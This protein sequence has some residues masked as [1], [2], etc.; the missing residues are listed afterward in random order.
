MTQ[1][2]IEIGIDVDGV[3]ESTLQ[4][5]FI[6]AVSSIPVTIPEGSISEA[7]GTILLYVGE[8]SDTY[9]KGK[10]YQYTSD[11]WSVYELAIDSELDNKVDKETGKGLSTNDFTDAQRTKL[12]GIEEGATKN[13][14]D[15][16]VKSDSTNAIQNKVI[17]EYVDVADSAL[18]TNIDTKVDKVEGKGLS[19]NDFT[20]ELKD[21]LEDIETGAQV[22]KVTDVQAGSTSVLDGTIAK[23]GTASSKDV[24]TA[25]G[26][27]PVLDSSGKLSNEVIPPLAIAEYIGEVD[28]KA[29]LITLSKAEKGD[30]AQVTDDTNVNNNGIWF[31]NGVYSE[32]SS[33]I[34]IVG[35]GAVISV[36]GHSGE[37]TLSAGDV[38]AVP[39]SRTVN[40]KALEA[41]IT[42]DADDV[43]ALTETVADS[44]YATIDTVEGKQNAI[45]SATNQSVSEWVEDSTLGGDFKY[46]ATLTLTGCTESMI[47][48]VVFAINQATS[49]DYAPICQS[50]TDCVYIW[51]TKNDAISGITVMAIPQ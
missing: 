13:T 29:D 6:G 33:W 10:Y 2:K 39:T 14:V 25:E 40:G 50:G 36:N 3:A 48:Q 20:T 49:S 44:K 41:D 42:L 11:G 23:L 31:L 35:P 26:N 21:K 15:D 1:K 16:I 9:T 5:K 37:V 38:G 7:I 17:K 46:K 28:T 34:Q 8:N 47:P 4:G 19:T 51:S 30:I 32:L 18:Q 24:G 27:V 22:N 45:I 12:A 43:G